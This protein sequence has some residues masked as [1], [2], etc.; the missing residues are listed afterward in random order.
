M[1]SSSGSSDHDN[2]FSAAPVSISVATM[3]LINIKSHVPMTL[4]VGDSNFTVGRT[5]FNI[6]F[7][8]FGIKDHVDGTVDA[9]AML[10]DTE[11]TQIDTCIVSWLYTMLFAELLSAIVQPHDNTY[12]VWTSIGSQFLDNIVQRT[13]QLRQALHALCQGDLTVTK[14]CNQLKDLADKLRDVGAPLTDQ[15]LIINLLSGLNDKFAN[16]IPTISASRP[17]MTFLQARSF[18]LQEEI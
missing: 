4:G 17:P 13:V 7:R 14:Y 10:L 1:A 11:W 16:C 9:R 3:Q 12:T 18:L 15:D 2:P 6:V 5:F 8:K